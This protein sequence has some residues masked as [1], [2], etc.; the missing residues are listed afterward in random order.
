MTE[1][2]T[3]TTWQEAFACCREQD[4]PIVAEVAGEVCRLFPSGRGEILRPSNGRLIPVAAFDSTAK[5]DRTL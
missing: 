1:P 5:E 3:F 2:L 4:R